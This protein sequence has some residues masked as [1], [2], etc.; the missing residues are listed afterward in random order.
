MTFGSVT[1][2]G[3]VEALTNAVEAT[4][5]DLRQ[6]AVSVVAGFGA[7]GIPAVPCLMRALSDPELSVRVEATNALIW[8][9]DVTMGI[10]KR[11]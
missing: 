7:D 9:S 11:P 10:V 5:A 1:A 2:P 4:D 3:V 8:L 6:T